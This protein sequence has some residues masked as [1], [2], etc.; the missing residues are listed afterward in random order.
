[1]SPL[2]KYT[3]PL[4]LYVDD[5]PE[6]LK[7]FQALFRR[8]YTIRLA[9]SAD[10]ALAILR[11][12]EI[13]V[14]VTDQRMPHVSGAALL[15][16]AAEEFPGV[17]RYMLTGYS[18]FDPLVDAINK[19]RVQ[20]YFPKPLN[21]KEFAERVARDLENRLLRERNEALLAEL[22]KSQEMLRQAHALARIGIWRWDRDTDTIEWSD[23]LWRIV[24]RAPGSEPLSFARLGH[25]F[26][27]PGMERLR[28]AV[29]TALQS[30]TPYQ[31]EL[32]MLRPDADVRWV[33]AFGGPTRD[34]HGLIIGLHGTVQDITERK[35]AE[36]AL[37]RAMEA[38]EAA[39]QAKSEFLANMS[40][41]IRTPLNGILGMLQLIQTGAAD[42][43]QARYAD[44]AI[45]SSKRLTCL[46]SDILDFSSMEA[47]KMT[48]H[49]EPFDIRG[50]LRQVEDLLHPVH[51]QSGVPLRLYADPA[52]PALVKGDATRVQQVL[53]NLVGNAL[54]FTESGSVAL[55]AYPLP[56]RRAA[57]SRALFVVADTGC[58]I[59]DEKLETLFKPFVQAS[60]GY[61]RSHQGAGLGLSIVKRLVELMGGSIAVESEVGVGTTFYVALPF[62]AVVP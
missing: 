18:D 27:P 15:E 7:S 39:N 23:E 61:S 31:L 40:H 33:T 12:E 37:L 52:L 35:R 21:P 60:T 28:Q 43:E 17:L 62:T 59:P 14:L 54:K 56:P 58:G 30:A 22:Q 2:A 48:L 42:P 13:H 45:R 5:E 51:L 49:A 47:G 44:I 36:I 57:E 8:D 26:S 16:Q 29:D 46:L 6:N 1:M 19:G 32:E 34:R 50:V 9:E 4:M 11:T 24:G 55:E 20:G 25:F 3:K 38:A 41:E 53:T 10:E